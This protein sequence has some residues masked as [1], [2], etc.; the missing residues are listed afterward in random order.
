MVALFLILL[1]F[2]S[3]PKA[4]AIILS[5]SPFDMLRVIIMSPLSD[6]L[7]MGSG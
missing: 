6:P 2:V 5:L 4:A 3:C 1:L 7:S